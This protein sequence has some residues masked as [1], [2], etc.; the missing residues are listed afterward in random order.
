LPYW[1]GPINSDNFSTKHVQALISFPFNQ[2]EESTLVDF[3]QEI[4][5]EKSLKFL[6]EFYVRRKR[7]A[8]AIQINEKYL[9]QYTGSKSDAERQVIMKNLILCLPTPLRHTYRI[10]IQSRPVDS[11]ASKTE[12]KSMSQSLHM[13]GSRYNPE[14]V[15]KVLQE[16]YVSDYKPQTIIS[17]EMI[18]NEDSMDLEDTFE[19]RARP[20]TPQTPKIV[21]EKPLGSPF[22]KPPFTPPIG[23]VASYII[24]IV[25]PAEAKNPVLLFPGGYLMDLIFFQHPLFSNL[26][27]KRRCLNLPH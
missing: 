4:K 2:A 5:S 27:K 17:A 7:F 11:L 9:S 8:E 21:A 19:A 25:E 12:R 16:N 3:C 14:Q 10:A 6:L 26:L 22:V 13:Q 24:L 23:N 18:P 15:I 20:E 1:Y